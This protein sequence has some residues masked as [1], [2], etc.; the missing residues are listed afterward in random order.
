MEEREWKERGEE[1]IP[2]EQKME[3][4]IDAEVDRGEIAEGEAVRQSSGQGRFD[5]IKQRLGS[6]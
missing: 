4:K 3:Q 5:E 1:Q 2:D 6:L